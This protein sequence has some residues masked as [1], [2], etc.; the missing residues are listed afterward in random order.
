M[1]K[2]KNKKHSDKEFSDFQGKTFKPSGTVELIIY[3]DEFKGVPC[4][5]K[6]FLVSRLS[7]FKIL[8]GRRTIKEEGLLA[9]RPRETLG[10]AAHIGL[11]PKLSKSK[12]CFR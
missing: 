3:S 9:R 11:Q 6:L 10:D 4:R 7:T 12:I 5:Q 1:C 2:E 8:L